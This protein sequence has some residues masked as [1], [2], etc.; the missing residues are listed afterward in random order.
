MSP[1]LVHQKCKLDVFSYHLCLLALGDQHDFFFQGHLICSVETVCLLSLKKGKEKN[2][3]PH[4]M[5]TKTPEQ[6]Q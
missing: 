5:D 2:P 1:V 6:W 3:K 4:N